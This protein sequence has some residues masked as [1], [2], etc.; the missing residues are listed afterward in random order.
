MMNSPTTHRATDR[1]K[2]K[3]TPV[4]TTDRTYRYL[5]RD[6]WIGRYYADDFAQIVFDHLRNGGPFYRDT[7][8]NRFRGQPLQRLNEDLRNRVANYTGDDLSAQDFADLGLKVTI[9]VAERRNSTGSAF[10]VYV[11]EPA[12][13]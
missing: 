12:C 1:Q 7:N 10:P 4:P 9:G 8:W 2:R 6:G 13:I 5:M 3:R 11:V